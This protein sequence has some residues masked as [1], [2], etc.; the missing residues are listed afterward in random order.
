MFENGQ[1]TRWKVRK[2]ALLLQSAV[3]RQALV[4]EARRLQPVLAWVD[5]GL[6]VARKARTALNVLAPWLPLWQT[7]R[8]ESS[9]V[10]GKLA[11]A[12]SFGRSLSALWKNWRQ[13]DPA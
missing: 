2:A 3:N 6:V 12:V 9:G 7:G 4:E 10:F 11:G 13:G 8:G 5:L 1:L